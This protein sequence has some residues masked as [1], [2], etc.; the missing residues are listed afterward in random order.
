MLNRPAAALAAGVL[1]LAGTVAAAPVAAS[2]ATTSYTVDCETLV[3]DEVEFPVVPGDTVTLELTGFDSYYDFV[4]DS[5]ESVDESGDTLVLSSGADIVL[6]SDSG[7]CVDD[8]YASVFDAA[9]ETVPGGSLLFTADITIPL[10]A[11]EIT[12]T[13]DVDGEHLLGGK[14]DCDLSTEVH[15]IHVFGTLDITV[16]NAGTY[17]FRGMRST[18]AGD[19]VPINAFD[20]MGD[21]MLA[22]Y[23]SFDPANP[24]ANVVGCNDD[25]NDVG[26]ENDAEYLTDGTIIDG[27]QPW[28][29]APLAPGS[30][31]LVLMTWEDLSS[32]DFA[33]GYAPYSE[34][35]FVVGPKSTTFQLWGPTGGLTLGHDAPALAATGMDATPVAVVGVLA[36]LAGLGALTVVR[37]RAA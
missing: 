17:T 12:V 15:G 28:F 11:P 34:E 22:V 6:Y 9:P 20:P 27:H 25:L 31:T 29:S 32:E 4:N 2:A 8:F 1:A 26:A 10:G 19:Y 35:E 37:R 33:E 7:P 3:I 18:P 36:L 16:T 21:P 24:D 23:S 5:T 14:E 13:E 30:Y